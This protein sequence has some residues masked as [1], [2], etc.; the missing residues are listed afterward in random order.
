MR[1]SAVVYKSTAVDY[2]ISQ[3]KHENL[4]DNAKTATAVDIKTDDGHPELDL[5][6]EN[7]QEAYRS[8]TTKELLRAYFVFQICTVPVIVKHNQKVCIDS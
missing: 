6:F 8:K 3:S 5:S 4:N 2:D 1:K 7:C